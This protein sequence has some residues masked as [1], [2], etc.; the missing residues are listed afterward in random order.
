MLNLLLFCME[1]PV[2]IVD[3]H[4]LIYA[5]NKRCSRS[6][7]VQNDPDK[8]GRIYRLCSL[9]RPLFFYQ[10][11]SKPKLT[12]HHKIWR[13]EINLKRNIDIR[14][15]KKTWTKSVFINKWHEVHFNCNFI[16]NLI[17]NIS[18]ILFALLNNTSK[19]VAVRQ[20]VI[21]HEVL[22]Q[23]V[24]NKTKRTAGLIKI[25]FFISTRQT[26]W[27][28]KKKIKIINYL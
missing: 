7:S 8:K 13:V 15:N 20:R 14:K 4:I 18:S 24:A 11:L 12:I 26:P 25:I 17:T 6:F 28:N 1:W 27:F 10:G 9:I 21:K 16:S 3:S 19:L 23:V 2:H 5:Y 22:D